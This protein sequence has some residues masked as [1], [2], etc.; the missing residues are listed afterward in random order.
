MQCS[1]TGGGPPV[2]SAK[3]RIQEMFS[4]WGSLDAEA[5][6]Q[7]WEDSPDVTYV[8]P[9]LDAILV[10]R[11]AIAAH[12]ARISTRLTSAQV[13]VLLLDCRPLGPGIELGV[14]VVCWHTTSFDSPIA[15]EAGARITVV[16]RRLKQDWYVVHYMEEAFHLSP[17]ADGPQILA[18]I[19][20]PF[21]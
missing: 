4:R 12:L 15:R 6:T 3:V 10:G 8:A 21:R 20:A 1:T 9:E 17:G 2:T 19:E 16:M 11:S 7:L 18:D 5:I 14:L 13:D